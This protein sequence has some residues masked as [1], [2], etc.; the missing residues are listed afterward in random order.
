MGSTFGRS[1]TYSTP[2][3]FQ[4]MGFTTLERLEETSFVGCPAPLLEVI[5]FVDSLRHSYSETSSPMIP[6]DCMP[7][8]AINPHFQSD[9][10][11]LPSA[12]LDHILSFDPVPWAENIQA[13]TG[14]ND[15]QS[16]FHAASGY[17]IAVYLYA[18]RVNSIDIPP[19]EHD[20]KVNSLFDHILAI[21]PTDEVVKCTIWSTFIAGAESNSQAQRQA[22]LDNLDK[23]WN[24]IFSANLRSASMVL[25]TLWRRQAER[26]E[27][28]QRNGE[29]ELN[30]S[31]TF[32]WIQ[33][34]DR[35]E[36]SWLFI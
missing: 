14:F 27:E 2:L 34:L 21:P 15:Y 11:D 20:E 12:L 9:Q 7:P 33:E 28:L 8:F 3:Y 5:L 25:K 30:S 31:Q 22:A 23:I 10:T 36:G 18:A 24:V 19:E 26:R 29:N 16:R 17:R 1:G 4:L 32:N 6:P 35:T 13:M